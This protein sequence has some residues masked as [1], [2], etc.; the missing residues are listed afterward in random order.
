[1]NERREPILGKPAE[2]AG[3]EERPFAWRA[4]AAPGRAP[5]EPGRGTWPNVNSE[6]QLVVWLAVIIVGTAIGGL[7]AYFAVRWYETR[8][9]EVALRQ[10]T[11]AVTGSSVQ[12]Q[13]EIAAAQAHARNQAV[14]AQLR[15][16]Q[17]RAERAAAQRQA[18]EAEATR[19]AAASAEAERKEAAWQKFY[20]RSD[21]CKNPDNRTT[22]ECANEYARAKKDFERRWA[23]EQLR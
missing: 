13:R 8:Q 23:A 6:S 14:A 1:M 2:L 17:E 9:M 5:F 15:A 3:A 16:E 7:I 21:F 18:A 22:I 20:L 11:Q 4:L 19:V 12:A 10:F